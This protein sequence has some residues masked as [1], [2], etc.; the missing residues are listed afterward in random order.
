[1]LYY[2]VLYCIMLRYII[3]YYVILYYIILSYIILYCIIFIIL[4]CFIILFYIILYYIILYYIILYYIISYYIKLKDDISLKDHHIKFSN[5]YISSLGSLGRPWNLFGLLNEIPRLNLEFTKR[6][7][8]YS[9]LKAWND[10]PIDLRE[11]SSL[12]RFK[13]NLKEYHLSED[14]N[15]IA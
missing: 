9:G 1:M 6:G 2:I 8:H 13:R 11:I 4:L 14:R 7:F 12:D 3:L 10:I 5:L 15:T